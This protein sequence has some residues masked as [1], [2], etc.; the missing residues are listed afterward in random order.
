MDILCLFSVLSLSTHIYIYIFFFENGSGN[1][2]KVC[3][4]GEKHVG[5]NKGESG[6]TR[7]FWPPLVN[8]VQY[9]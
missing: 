1:E 8:A 7:G 4:E 2:I 9:V 3:Y 5:E 6:S